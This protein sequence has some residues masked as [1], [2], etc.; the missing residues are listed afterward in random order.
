MKTVEI[1]NN[2]KLDIERLKNLICQR[3]CNDALLL[4]D[5]LMDDIQ[6]D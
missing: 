3:K 1:L 2:V 4:V 6:I 5:E